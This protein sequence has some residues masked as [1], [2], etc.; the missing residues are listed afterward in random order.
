MLLAAAAGLILFQAVRDGFLSPELVV[1]W[2]AGAPGAI[3][4]E[5]ADV[6]SVAAFL[7]PRWRASGAGMVICPG[8][9]YKMLMT[10]YEDDDIAH[11]LNSFG[12]AG[13]VLSYRIAP[14]II[15]RRRC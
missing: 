11:W 5:A 1:L 8:G 9:V 7:P 13:F 3:G 4:S 15:T 2:P 12:G 10:S 6:P 14:A